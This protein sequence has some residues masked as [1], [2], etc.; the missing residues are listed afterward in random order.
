MSLSGIM[1][2]ATA[3]LNNIEYEISVGNANIANAGDT[4]YTRKVVSVTPVS[5]EL[6]V[7]STTTSRVTD[8]YLTKTVVS[9]NSAASRDQAV[10]DILQNYD[11]AL[12][13]TTDGDDLSTLLTNLQT[14]L[15][16]IS[17]QG[18][19]ASSKVSFVSAAGQLATSINNLSATIQSLRTE[20]NSQIGDTVTDIN[21]L[22]SQIDSLNR[23]IVSTQASGGDVTN[24]EDQRDAALQSLSSDIGVSYY[25]TPQNTMQVFTSSG[26][27]LVG[28]SAAPL[29]FSDGTSSLS[30]STT[31][32][33]GIS[34][35]TLGGKDVTTSISSG[36]LSGL[37]SL[38]DQTLPAE[39]AKLDNLSQGLISTANAIS[40]AG[41]ASPPPS[42]LTGT[43]TVSDSDPITASGTLTVTLT[44]SSGVVDGAPTQIDL[45]AL[46]GGGTITIQQLRDQL[47][48]I[49]GL[50]AE[51]NSK[52]Q[53]T[54]STTNGDGVALSGGTLASASATAAP[55]SVSGYFGLN[56]IFTGSGAADIA[57]NASLT[58]NPSLLATAAL[59]TTAGANAIGVASGDTSNVDALSKALTTGQS[60]AA[61]G[62]LAAQT[63]SLQSYAN[64][65]VSSAASLISNASSTSQTSQATF[66]AAQTR[67]QNQTSVNTNEELAN[68]QTLQQQYQANAQMISTVRTLFS[69]LIQMMQG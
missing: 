13:S 33:G 12:G 60:F 1:N 61:A 53:L 59:D 44:N 57:V 45:S 6:S 49:S 36:K 30:A 14:A 5:P 21:N 31:Y 9:S 67:L 54:I 65:F 25:I 48:T 40:N 41:T 17:A 69:A 64:L 19:D 62:G 11:S 23:Q 32:P 42:T 34:G 51:I 58:A 66:T 50:D 16:N 35:L 24:L 18:G 47:N 37:I 63:T 56:D 46:S 39:Q 8:A 55:S 7:S 10:S 22:T 43:K 52:G 68:L 3:A 20:A 27:L 29:S 38:R 15:T 4:S 28:E 2:T 26:D